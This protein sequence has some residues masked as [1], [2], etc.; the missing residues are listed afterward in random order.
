MAQL[1]EFAQVLAPDLHGSRRSDPL[2]VATPWWA[3]DRDIV[4]ALADHAGQKVHV[5]GHSLGGAAA[6]YAARRYPQCVASLTA[7]EPVLFGLLEQIADPGF[8]DATTISNEVWGLLEAGEDI[9]AAKAFTDFWS[10]EGTFIRLQ[11]HQADYVV[12]T[13]ARVG[14]RNTASGLGSPPVE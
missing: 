12:Q 4:K 10:G 5:I 11:P 3:A 2:P 9:K 13:I 14:Q 8:P 6:F 1:S 7:I